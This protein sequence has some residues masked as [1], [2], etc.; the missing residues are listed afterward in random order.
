MTRFFAICLALSLLPKANAQKVSVKDGNICISNSGGEATPL[1]S[2]GH[3]SEPALSPDGKWIVFVRTI[4]GKT[5]STGSG[6]SLATELWQIRADG[7]QP[8]LLVKPRGGEVPK[9]TIAG[10]ANLQFS[11]DGRMVYFVVPAFAVTGAV[12]VVDT[13]NGKERFFLGGGAIEVIQSGEYKDCLLVEQHRYFIGGGSYDW[14]WLFRS[15]GKEIGPVGE[16]TESF[17]ST[18]APD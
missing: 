5:I 13:T 12:H 8:T 14:W 6:D 16:D 3:D 18:Y 1:T 4:P 10:I 7:K 11:S 2:S 17:K 15:D 9:N